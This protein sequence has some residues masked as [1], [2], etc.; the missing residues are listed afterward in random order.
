MAK[1][2]KNSLRIVGGKHGGRKLEIPEHGGVRPTSDRAREALFNILAHGDYRTPQG[3]MPL[4]ARVLDVFAGSG[5]LGLEAL[6]RG[7]GHVSFLEQNPDNL[8][9]IRKNAF[10]LGETT[11]VSMMSRDGTKPGPLPTGDQVPADLVLLDAPY[12]SGLGDVALA[13]L[14]DAGWLAETCIAALEVAAK[15]EVNPP[16][17]FRIM[18]ERKYGA[19]K[20]VFLQKSPA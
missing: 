2:V 17:G 13:A 1:N 5:A 14:D 4:G 18:D 15:E 7:A 19:A 3:P 10:Q 12:D 6:S 20:L 16:E 11:S 8:K 9:L